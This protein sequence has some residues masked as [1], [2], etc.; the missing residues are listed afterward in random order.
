MRTRTGRSPAAAMMRRVA[1]MPSSS[2]IRMSM[3]TTS[4]SRSLAIVTALAPSEASPTTSRSSSASRIILNPARTSAWSSAIRMRT[5]ISGVSSARAERGYPRSGMLGPTVEWN[6]GADL[7]AAAGAPARVQLAAEDAHALAHADEAV[8]SPAH[9]TGRPRPGPAIADV[10]L[11]ILRPIGDVHLGR[12]RGRVLEGVR[13]VGERR[14]RRER[15]LVVLAAQHAEQ[16]PDLGQRVAARRLDGGE[17]ERR[18]P[19]AGPRVRRRPLGVEEPR[20]LAGVEHHPP[21]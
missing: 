18:A 19:A 3:S 2:G 17:G 9:A 6:P 10:Q 21:Q 1:S 4:G 7:E 12:C 13:D 15:Q 8:A 20:G 16:S 5:V 14:L 11:E